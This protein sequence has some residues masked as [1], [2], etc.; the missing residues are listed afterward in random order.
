MAKI[1]FFLIIFFIMIFPVFISNKHPKVIM[2]KQENKPLIEII[3]GKYKKYNNIL[4]TNGSFK[5][6]KIYSNYYEFNNLFANNLIK[7]EKYFAKWAL[8]KGNIIKIE[9]VKYIN[10][11]YNLT[12]KNVIYY[13][14]NSLL[15]GWEFNFS[16]DK[17]RG[18]GKY[19]EID[20]NKNL[21]AKNIIYFIKV[22]K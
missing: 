21:Y 3:D 2:K 8:K 14:T 16:S 4:E 20:K 9:F 11:D 1:V 7:K 19:F 12:S 13:E 17:A 15:K 18:R 22:E 10:N 5:K 6:G